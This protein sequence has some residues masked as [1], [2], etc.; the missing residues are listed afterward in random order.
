[1]MLLFSCF[2]IDRVVLHSTLRRTGAHVCSN[3]VN[4]VDRNAENVRNY[5]SSPRADA[6]C[7]YTRERREISTFDP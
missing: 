5:A 7:A 1:M 6:R 3:A 2:T 4:A